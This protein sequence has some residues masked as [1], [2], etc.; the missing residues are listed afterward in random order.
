MCIRD[1]LGLAIVTHTG[2]GLAL[3]YALGHLPASLVAPTLLGQPVLAAILAIPILGEGLSWIQ[4]GG[5]AVVLLGIYLVH[6]SRG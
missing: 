2:G 5:G 4:I 3:N 1:R 6:R